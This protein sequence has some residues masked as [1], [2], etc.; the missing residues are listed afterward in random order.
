M[1][2]EKIDPARES[3]GG[4]SLEGD[5]LHIGGVT[6][7]LSE[8]QEDQEKIIT[9]GSCDGAVHRGLMPCCTYA[10]DVIIPPRRYAL[11]ETGGEGGETETESAP[12]PLDTESVVLRLWPIAGEAGEINHSMDMEEE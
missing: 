8:E 5:T 1:I 10:A 9:L 3:L 2:I 12:V 7:N 11:H 6:L 4:Y